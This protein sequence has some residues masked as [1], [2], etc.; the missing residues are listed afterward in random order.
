M[1]ILWAL[2]RVLAENAN[3]S[4]MKINKCICFD[5]SFRRIYKEAIQDGID[6]LPDL[7]RIKNICN[8]CELCNPYLNVV[9]EEGK[10]EF[11]EKIN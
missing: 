4:N 11:S 6:N 8:K 5:R 3:L 2:L 10:F 7:Q 9:F 1:Q